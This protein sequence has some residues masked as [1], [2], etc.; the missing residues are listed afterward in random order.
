M[1][2]DEAEAAKLAQ[3]ILNCVRDRRWLYWPPG[4]M[5]SQVFDVKQCQKDLTRYLEGCIHPIHKE[6]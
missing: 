1:I 5:V 6:N 3:F 2:V 4:P